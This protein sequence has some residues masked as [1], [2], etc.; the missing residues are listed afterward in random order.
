MEE[1]KWNF[2]KAIVNQF[3]WDSS[4]W[5]YIKTH[6]VWILIIL[7]LCYMY[8][9]ETKTAHKVYSNIANTCEVY[10]NLK[11]NQVS[12][13]SILDINYSRLGELTIQN[14]TG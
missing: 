6:I 3:K 4:D 2:K 9:T 8:Y 10:N 1:K 11:A 13:G 14:V 5:N 7:L 12:S